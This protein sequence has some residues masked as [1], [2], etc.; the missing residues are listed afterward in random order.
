MKKQLISIILL[1]A[2]IIPMVP[3]RASAETTALSPES[4]TEFLSFLSGN[5]FYSPEEDDLYY[6][7]LT[8]TNQS[9]ALKQSFLGLVYNSTNAHLYETRLNRLQMELEED[10]PQTTKDATLEVVSGAVKDE[11]IESFAGISDAGDIWE[12]F[13]IVL[14][15]VFFA[16]N[17]RGKARSD[18]F[19]AM[20]GIDPDDTYYDLYADTNA[21]SS[22]V[23]VD[24]DM[25][26]EWIFFMYAIE[27]DVLGEESYDES[28]PQTFNIT[29][30]SNCS[31]VMS[32]T[33]T[34]TQGMGN[35]IPPTMERDGYLFG[36]W[37][38]D[39]EGTVSANG[40]ILIDRDITLYA[41]WINR[42]QTIVFDSNCDEVAD[43]VKVYDVL[44]ENRIYPEMKRPGY[45][46]DGWYMDAACTEAVTSYSSVK[47]YTFYAKWL[48]RYSYTYENGGITITKILIAE[49]TDSDNI[50]DAVPATI[51]GIPVLK[52]GDSAFANQKTL[53]QVTIPEGVTEIGKKAFY[54]CYNLK[55]AFLPD[56]ITSIS[57]SAFEYCSRLMEVT[58]P[59]QLKH[60]GNYGF[61]MCYLFD[62]SLPDG[63]ETIGNSAFADNALHYVTIPDSVTT[64]GSGA[65]DSCLDLKSIHLGKSVSYLGEY[66]LFSCQSLT[67]I[68][69]SEENPFYCA[70]DG[71][72]YSKDKSVIYRYPEGDYSRISYT[73][74]DGC[75]E[76]YKGA[77]SGAE[78]VTIT[79]PDTVATIGKRA[80]YYT[81]QLKNI[82]LS[83]GLTK[84][85]KE[86]FVGSSIKAIIMPASVTEIPAE[87]FTMA[88]SLEE[89][90]F[91]GNI[92]S[93]GEKAFYINTQLKNV[94]CS[95]SQEEWSTVTMGSQN[96][97]FTKAAFHFD[98]F[99]ASH[100]A[101]VCGKAGEAT[102]EY[103]ISSQDVGKVLICALYDD[104]QC[105]SVQNVTTV[106]GINSFNLTDSFDAVKLFL[107][108]SLSSAIP[109]CKSEVADF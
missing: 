74:A 5:A 43:E 17:V 83:K 101:K 55:K 91:E 28:A 2:I 23:G 105:V 96:S 49:G 39:A 79:M 92:T 11:L 1:C 85:D 89:I 18:Y 45:V 32:V 86:L 12:G 24:K 69:V 63:L 68:T 77:F 81:S 36:G 44:D 66:E 87:A 46:F 64:L 61:R 60:I 29:F 31:E 33:Y 30:N 84:L 58:F 21:I 98:C 93:V 51:N 40:N 78:L 9:L 34:H 14:N 13:Q 59:K 7:L 19:S 65:F 75:R 27:Q 67:T 100:I 57:D 54:N 26:D 108:E 41:I 8:G 6:S 62:I 95:Q 16:F 107:W 48:A 80:F 52:I 106:E 70:E 53:R 38:F 104:D 94:Y 88:M 15:T 102:A 72:L 82:T 4:A 35:A 25:V 56:S 3:I 103:T 99:Y 109:V 47:S 97:Y 90:T 76:I 42:N 71:V 73:I 50:I 22:G 37:A 20:I 10:L